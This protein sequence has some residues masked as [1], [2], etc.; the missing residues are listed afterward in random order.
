M[1]NIVPFAAQVYRVVMEINRDCLLASGVAVYMWRITL[2]DAS[3]ACQ[4]VPFNMWYF[5]TKL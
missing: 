3:S 2:A 5:C 1:S 4:E